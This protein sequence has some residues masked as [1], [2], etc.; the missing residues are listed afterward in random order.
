MLEKKKFPGFLSLKVLSRA[1]NMVLS[2]VLFEQRMSAGAH[3]LV[4]DSGPIP[5]SLASVGF[6]L[7]TLKAGPSR[8]GRLISKIV[9]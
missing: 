5:S 6:K 7:A 8:A 9:T 2:R 1:V 4:K 3:S